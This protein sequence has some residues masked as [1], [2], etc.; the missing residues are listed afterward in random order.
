MLPGDP[1]L[2]DGIVVR[3]D[4]EAEL[5]LWVVVAGQVG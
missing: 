5:V 4:G 2:G 1:L 3:V